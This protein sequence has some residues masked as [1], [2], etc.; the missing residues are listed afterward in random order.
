MRRIVPRIISFA[1]ALLIGIAVAAIVRRE[2]ATYLTCGDMFPSYQREERLQIDLVPDSDF[3]ASV[4]IKRPFFTAS[5][6]FEVLFDGNGVIKSVRPY[7]MLPY[8]VSEGS[9]EF[10]DATPFLADGKFVTTLPEDVIQLATQQILS[11]QYKPK[12]VNGSP[13]GERAFVLI[14]Y[15]YADPEYADLLDHID[16]TITDD[17]AVLWQGNTWVSR[18]QGSERRS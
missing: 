14:E 6:R 18:N 12:T 8:G 1:C 7:P 13:V 16:V 5:A 10:A 17:T 4:K 11:I 15:S 3:A 9:A 2:S